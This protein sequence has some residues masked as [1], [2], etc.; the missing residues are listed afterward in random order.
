M[1]MVCD[2]WNISTALWLKRLETSDICF[3]CKNKKLNFYK[4]DEI[5]LKWYFDIQLSSTVVNCRE[6]KRRP[7]TF[8]QGRGQAGQL[9]KR[10]PAEKNCASGAIEQL[11]SINPGPVFDFKRIIAQTRQKTHAQHIGG[12]KFI[13]S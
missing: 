5:S 8:L 10:I 3:L 4:A 2:N 7:I 12:K 9:G 11:L 6:V 1:K 13:F